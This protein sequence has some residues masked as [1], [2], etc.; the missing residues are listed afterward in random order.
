MLLG[1]LTK[2]FIRVFNFYKISGKTAA[3]QP[4]MDESALE[5]NFY[6]CQ[7]SISATIRNPNAIRRSSSPLSS[8]GVFMS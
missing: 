8:V 3:L 4:L 7:E 2:T 1:V 6:Y 5:C